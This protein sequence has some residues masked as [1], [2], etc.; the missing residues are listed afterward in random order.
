MRFKHFALLF[1]VVAVLAAGLTV[2]GVKAVRARGGQPPAPVVV[3]INGNGAVDVKSGDQARAEEARILRESLEDGRGEEAKA[4]ASFKGLARREGDVLILSGPRGDIASFTDAELC[5]GFDNCSRWRFLGEFPV[6][7]RRY[8]FVSFYHGEGDPMPMLVDARGEFVAF[9]QGAPSASPDGRWLVIGG[10]DAYTGNLS[11]FSVEP[12]GMT[13]VADSDDSCQ[14]DRWLDATRLQL[15]CEFE[16]GKTAKAVLVRGADWRIES[17]GR[18]P[19]VI[20][21]TKPDVDDEPSYYESKGYRRL[22]R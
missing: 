4:L 7:A 17:E 12:S 11:I 21:A 20:P 8:P 18:K 6:G 22:A 9:G 19:T 14:P 3:E 5:E 16:A 13:L 15:T 2:V 1:V 10:W